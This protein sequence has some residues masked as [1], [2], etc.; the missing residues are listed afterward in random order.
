MVSALSEVLA[1]RIAVFRG[2]LVS[3]EIRAFGLSS[4][5]NDPFVP[6]RQWMRKNLA[7]EV[8]NGDLCEEDNRGNLTPLWTGVELQAT[9]EASSLPAQPPAQPTRGNRKR[10]PEG[11]EIERIIKEH[12][13]DADKVGSK[14]AAAAVASHMRNPPLLEN[15]IRAL[16]KQVARISKAV[17]GTT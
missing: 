1:D 5:Y 11:Q 2:L 6:V 14:A 4:V 15:A 17:N 3:G 9:V 16:E 8:A 13:I 7:I 10:S 12:R